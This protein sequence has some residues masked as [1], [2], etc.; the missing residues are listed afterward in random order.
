MLD[1]KKFPD[2]SEEEDIRRVYGHPE[3]FFNQV[4]DDPQDPDKAWRQ[5]ILS[6]PIYFPTPV[7]RGAARD[8]STRVCVHKL[9]ADNLR[10]IL[11]ELRVNNLWRFVQDSGG[12]YNFRSIRGGSRLSNHAW[13]AAIDLNTQRY[14]LGRPADPKDGFILRVVPVFQKHGWFWGGDYQDRKDCQHFEAVRWP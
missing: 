6:P 4:G 13:A 14:P 3:A 1:P 11:D 12:A 5:A 9:L 2:G 10:E 8:I 7:E